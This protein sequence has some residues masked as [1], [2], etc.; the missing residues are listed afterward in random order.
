MRA[1]F[2]IFLLLTNFS[3]SAYS[4]DISAKYYILMDYDTGEVLL[5]KN[6]FQPTEPSSM[7]KLMLIYIIFEKL[8]NKEVSLD[9]EVLVSK[10]AWQKGG[11]RMFLEL[12]SKVRLEDLILGSIVQSGNDATIAIAEFCSGSESAFVELMNTK[13]K[14]LGLKNS[15]FVNSTGWP[16]TGHVMSA[17]DIA[18]LSQKLIHDFPEYYH[19][20]SRKEFEHNNIKQGNRNPL[21][22]SD[23]YVDGLKTGRTDVA[24]FGVA[25]SAKKENRRLISVVNGCLTNSAREQDSKTLLG[26]GFNNFSN[27]IIAKN[28]DILCNATLHNGSDKI[29]PL[30]ANSDVIYTVKRVNLPKIN[31]SLLYNNPIVAPIHKGDV[32]G[33]IIIDGAKDEPITIELTSPQ[34]YEEASLW[35]KILRKLSL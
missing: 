16:D 6:A 7:S 1:F 27:I 11:S 28:G 10:E 35:Q 22:Y 20:F 8:K 3:Q 4:L 19:Y 13:L 2:I 23:P 5:E 24:G 31:V 30:I 12:N 9:D 18:I 26:Y 15:N 14:D 17:H 33:K 21:L 29:I 25:V 32:I 34:D